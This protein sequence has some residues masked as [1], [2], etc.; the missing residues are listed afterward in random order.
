MTRNAE[1]DA[2]LIALLRCA[3]RGVE[4]DIEGAETRAFYVGDDGLLDHLY[5]ERD[6]YAA[7]LRRLGD[8]P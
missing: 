5:A 3:L 8:L 2:N 1:E 7:D 6:A 4:Q